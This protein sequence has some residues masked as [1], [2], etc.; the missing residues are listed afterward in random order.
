M[1]GY[2]GGAGEVTSDD[3]FFGC[4][5]MDA[6]G[7]DAVGD[8]FEVIAEGGAEIE[9]LR[10]EGFVNEGAGDADHD[11]GAALAGVTV[12]F[13]AVTTEQGDEEFL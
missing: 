1:R 10:P 9:V 13:E 3:V 5:A 12:G 6:F 4:V 2:S 8:V 11:S 7:D